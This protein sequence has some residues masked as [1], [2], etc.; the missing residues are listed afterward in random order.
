MVKVAEARTVVWDF[1]AL[2]S[3]HAEER[4]FDSF[5]KAIE[6]QVRDKNTIVEKW[7]LRLKSGASK[8]NFNILLSSGRI[9]VKNMLS[10]KDLE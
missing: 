8:E 10:G 4:G 2:S 6:L 1:N 5:G 3:K 9:A 7:P